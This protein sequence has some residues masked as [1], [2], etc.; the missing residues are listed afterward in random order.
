MAVRL[1]RDLDDQ[2]HEGAALTGLSFLLWLEGAADEAMEVAVAGVAKLEAVAPESPAM[3]QA[4]AILAQRGLVAGQDNYSTQTAARAIE[5]AERLGEERIL[6]HALTTMG[7]AQIFLAEGD[8]WTTLEEA[9][10]R[11][12]AAGFRDETTRALIN[13]AETARDFRRYE[14]ADRYIREATDHLATHEVGLYHHLLNAR[15]AA[16]ELEAGRWSDA[17]DR[18]GSLLGHR[19]LANPIRV[20]ALTIVGLVQARRGLPSGERPLDEALS[21]VGDDLQDRP[22]VLAARA[23]AAWLAG[24]NPRAREEAAEGLSLA[25]RELS[26]WWWSELAFWGVKAGA[27]APLPQP[28]ERPY[29]LD[30]TGRH[31]EAAAE[32]ASLGAPYM[33]AIALA[34]SDLEPDLRRSLGICNALGARVLAKRVSRK[35]RELGGKEIARG[36]RAATLGN[37]RQLTARQLEILSLMAAGLGNR[38]IATRLVLSPKTVD[39][40]V[41]AVL[42]KLGVANRVLAGRAAMELG[43][44]LGPQDGEV[45]TPSW[46]A[47]RTVMDGQ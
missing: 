41:S 21:L 39:H 18:A 22:Q 15:I 16:L 17:L 1:W 44:R 19:R 24:D 10:A 2:E 34:E 11:G 47:S 42:R 25:P 7:V 27:T 46:G 28:A 45:P 31:R 3:A 12:R 5:L 38:Q 13:L 9:V 30:A 33:E 36:P 35:L 20:R 26:P 6:V 37:P 8:G 40:H 32:W 29:W 14:L 4:W 23:E 43:I